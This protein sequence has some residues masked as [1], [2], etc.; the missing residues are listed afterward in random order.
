MSV[1]GLGKIRNVHFDHV[2]INNRTVCHTHINRPRHLVIRNKMA[3]TSPEVS[4]Y[5]KEVGEK[6]KSN[7]D[8]P[9]DFSGNEGLT[10]DS[11]LFALKRL[12]RPYEMLRDSVKL[13]D[14]TKK[15]FEP[16]LRHL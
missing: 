12:L 4:I 9:Q 15:K 1:K 14:R 13:T 8:I 7:F 2:I 3:V 16:T 10:R 5:I 6:K 11:T